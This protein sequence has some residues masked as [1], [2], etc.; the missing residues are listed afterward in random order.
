MALRIVKEKRTTATQLLPRVTF[1]GLAKNIQR[2]LG[3]IYRAAKLKGEIPENLNWIKTNYKKLEAA[4]TGNTQAGTPRAV[5]SQKQYYSVLAHALLR[6]VDLK[7]YQDASK[8]ST[9]LSKAKA[10]E[11]A[12]GVM[13]PEDEANLV[14]HRQLVQW[15]QVLI[16]R[17]KDPSL[18][19]YN[20]RRANLRALA[21][22]INVL[23]PP[24]RLDEGDTLVETDPNSKPAKAKQNYIVITPNTVEFHLNEDKMIHQRSMTPAVYTWPQELADLVRD[25]LAF[26]PRRYL[27]P[28][29]L[30]TKFLDKPMDV[31]HKVDKVPKMFSML[32]S[33]ASPPGTIQTSRRLRISYV[34]YF[35]ARAANLAEKQR[36][37]DLMRHSTPVGDLVYNRT[38]PL[39]NIPGLP[40]PTPSP[41]ASGA[42]SGASALADQLAPMTLQSAARTLTP[43]SPAVSAA[44]SAA[45]A[46]APVTAVGGRKRKFSEKEYRARPDVKEKQKVV[47]R[48]FQ[49]NHKFRLALYMALRRANDRESLNG[50]QKASKEKYKLKQLGNGDW[51]SELME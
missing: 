50:P 26:F 51:I 11:Q 45:P 20:A 18:S 34:S 42:S 27:F 25:S 43:P 23:T 22:A 39:R 1:S 6:G 5:N 2:D 13:S 37:A 35:Y 4:I 15:L 8:K 49:Q 29:M 17:S 31:Y 38:I 33:E 32:L 46:P 36:I 28:K 10:A 16:A 47:N 12:E 7:M 24:L 40:P 14:D 48:E 21:L 30:V 41:T 44:I 3:V 19:Q 9:D